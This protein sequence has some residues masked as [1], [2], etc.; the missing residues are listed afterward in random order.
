MFVALVA[1]ASV[2]CGMP[3]TFEVDKAHRIL[4][5]RGT[6]VLTMADLLGYF[7]DSRADPDYDPAMHRMMD[8]REVTQLPS[9]DDIRALATFARSRAPVDTAR[10]AIIAS[11]DLAF[12]V[13]MMFKAFVGYGE[14]LIVVRDEAEAMEWL[15]KGQR[16]D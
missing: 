1:V 2:Y 8:L 13:S 10:M 15:T 9:S 5:S 4:R 3:L 12:G 14:R 16:R 7:A 11:S 6:G